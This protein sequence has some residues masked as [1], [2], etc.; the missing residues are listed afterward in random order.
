MEFKKGKIFFSNGFEKKLK[1]S[2]NDKF[3]KPGLYKQNRMFINACMKKTKI[4]YPAIR[5]EE[6]YN[7]MKFIGKIE[8]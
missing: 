8:K 2:K 5:S 4:K 7:L 1:I 3:F 6:M